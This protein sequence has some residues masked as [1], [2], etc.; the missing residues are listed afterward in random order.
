M[1]ENH[2]HSKPNV[3]SGTAQ[4]EL[5]KVEKQFEQFNQEVQ[6]L[7][8]D[9]M[10]E[11]PKEESEPQTKL[12]SRELQKKKEIYLKPKRTISS[13]EKFNEKFREDYNY[14]KEYVHFMAENKEIIGETINLWTKPYPGLPAEEWEV[15]VNTALWGPRYLAE[16]IKGSTY[17]RLSMKNTNLSGEDG[18]GTYYGTMVADAEVQRLD[19]YPVTEKKSVFMGASGF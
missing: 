4:K 3:S 2:T 13:R 18:M 7:T 12:S 9:R 6:S 5:D 14:S 19:A 8:L 16:R 15:P 17:H 11:A 1:K 10:K